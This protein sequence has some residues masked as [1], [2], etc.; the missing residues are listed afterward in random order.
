MDSTVTV[1]V[2][3][4][5]LP[6]CGPTVAASIEEGSEETTEGAVAAAAAAVI[7]EATTAADIAVMVIVDGGERKSVPSDGGEL[8]QGLAEAAAE[9]VKEKVENEEKKENN[10]TEAQQF[11]DSYDSGLTSND[12]GSDDRAREPSKT[13]SDT[14][15][16]S[17]IPSGSGAIIGTGVTAA[18]GAA[19]TAAS[20]AV[21]A[22]RQPRCSGCG[23]RLFHAAE[24]GGASDWGAL[25]PLLL[26]LLLLRRLHQFLRGYLSAT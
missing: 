11:E 13:T 24:G 17:S 4:G 10:V 26:P 19:K 20:P 16:A 22:P 18:G 25:P 3:A 14:A 9:A 8:G 2:T 7:A 23:T 12:K 15:S 6:P 1:T 5:P 21:L